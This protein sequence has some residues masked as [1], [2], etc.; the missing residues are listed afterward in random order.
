MNEKNYKSKQ[1]GGVINLDSIHPCVPENLFPNKNDLNRFVKHLVNDDG[2]KCTSLDKTSCI[3]WSSEEKRKTTPSNALFDINSLLKQGKKFS[4]PYFRING[5]KRNPRKLIALWFHGI[6]IKDKAKL[7]VDMT[8][9]NDKCMNPL[10]MITDI[11]SN[12][13]DET[14][15]EEHS[16]TQVQGETTDTGEPSDQD[17]EREDSS[18]DKEAKENFLLERLMQNPS[19]LHQFGELILDKCGQE[20][21]IENISNETLHII[22]NITQDIFGLKKK[23]SLNDNIIPKIDSELLSE[24]IKSGKA[25]PK[26]FLSPCLINKEHVLLA[27]QNRLLSEIK[28]ERE[29]ASNKNGTCGFLKE[30]S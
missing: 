20:K 21:I 27:N 1:K 9:E 24:F 13:L 5:L 17:T 23:L 28:R 6:E 26:N 2:C 4:S 14:K 25:L 10:H 12:S 11:N 22:Y 30:P 7:Y 18:E 8:C 19:V 29:K 16:T 15:T 3:F